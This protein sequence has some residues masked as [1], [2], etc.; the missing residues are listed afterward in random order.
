LPVGGFVAHFGPWI[1]AVDLGEFGKLADDHEK[2]RSLLRR[3]V[4]P[5]K[6]SRWLQLTSQL[7]SGMPFGK[8]QIVPSGEIK[9]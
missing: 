1:W 3:A 4:R 9:M 6:S 5:V 8:I 7:G 2:A